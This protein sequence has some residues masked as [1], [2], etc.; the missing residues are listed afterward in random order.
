MGWEVKGETES[1]DHEKL[2]QLVSAYL[3][4]E[5]SEDERRMVEKHL[6]EC[7]ECRQAC[8]ETSELEEVMAKMTLKEPPKEVWKMYTESVYNR[9]ERGIG[10]ILL[11]IGAMIVLFFAGYQ[12]LKGFILDPTISMVVKAGILCGLGGVVVLLVSLIRERLFVNKRER[13]KEIE[14]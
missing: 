7:A 6:E 4:G 12:A 5:V 2:K 1:M 3:D 14:K 13:Y 11:S 10:W 8:R 9:L